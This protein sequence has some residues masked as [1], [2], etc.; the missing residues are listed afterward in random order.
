MAVNSKCGKRCR[1]LGIQ[2]TGTLSSTY[3]DICLHE[4]WSCPVVLLKS[5]ICGKL[6][7]EWMVSSFQ[8]ERWRLS[9]PNIYTDVHYTYT[10]DT[11]ILEKLVGVEENLEK[12]PA[13]LIR[14]GICQIS[15]PSCYLSREMHSL[16]APQRGAVAVTGVSTACTEYTGYPWAV[17]LHRPA[18]QPW[19]ELR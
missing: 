15:P 2:V 18:R 19:H 3:S 13:P 1:R 8:P 4:T 5:C 16:A 9:I 7:R 6:G 10:S 12:L 14:E 17:E 11:P